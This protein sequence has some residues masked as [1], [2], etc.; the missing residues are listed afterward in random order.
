MRKK[1]EG[2]LKFQ[3]QE[4]ILPNVI[5]NIHPNVC[6]Q[7]NYIIWKRSCFISVA[8][9]FRNLHVDLNARFGED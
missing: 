5:S 8:I 3:V 4:S 9:H 6:E 7:E 2:S 1:L